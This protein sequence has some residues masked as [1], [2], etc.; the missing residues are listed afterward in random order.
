[1]GE[2]RKFT[3]FCEIKVLEGKMEIIERIQR[4]SLPLITIR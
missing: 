2:E 1:M 3:E 4:V